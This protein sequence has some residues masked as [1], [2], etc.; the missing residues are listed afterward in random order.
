MFILE[1]VT[2]GKK[3]KQPK[4][5]QNVEWFIFIYAQSNATKNETLSFAIT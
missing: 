1:L 4:C 2:I 5:P 3:Y